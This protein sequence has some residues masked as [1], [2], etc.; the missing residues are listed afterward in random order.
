MTPLSISILLNVVNKVA[1]GIPEEHRCH[2]SFINIPDLQ[3]PHGGLE[4][5]LEEHH[6]MM[7]N[8]ELGN[9]G[10]CLPLQDL[11]KVLHL[12]GVLCL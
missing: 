12:S 2:S 9:I 7:Q 6:T 11:P 10:P 1:A 4:H 5:V 8:E 3:I